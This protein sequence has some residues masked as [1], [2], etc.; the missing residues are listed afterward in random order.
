MSDVKLFVATKALIEY[1]GK[2]LILRESDAYADGTKAAQYDVAGG[3]MEP[4][5]HFRD[6]LLR[7]I[8]EETGLAV[9]VGE[10]FFVDEWRPVKNGEQWQI[11]GIFFRCTATSNA[12][13]LSA[14]HDDYQWINPAEFE[15]YAIIPAYKEVFAAYLKRTS[16]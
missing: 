10:P 9:E 12:V 3:R 5:E 11:V 15:R 6:S 14:D 13:R 2:V 1:E 7:E 4:G 8:N 16:S